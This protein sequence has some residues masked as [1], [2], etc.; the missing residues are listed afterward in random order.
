MLCIYIVN[1]A[2]NREKGTNLEV[3]GPNYV[4]PLE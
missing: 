2:D 3:D 1:F 4:T